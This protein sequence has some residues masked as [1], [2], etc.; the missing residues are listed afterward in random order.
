MC[1]DTRALLSRRHAPRGG[2]ERGSRARGAPLSQRSLMYG[3]LREIAIPPFTD[4]P[5]CWPESYW[6]EWLDFGVLGLSSFNPH[7]TA[8]CIALCPFQ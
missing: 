6:P 5:F 3:N 1:T 2:P 4:Q 7:L 8:Q